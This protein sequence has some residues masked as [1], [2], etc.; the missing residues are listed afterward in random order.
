MELVELSTRSLAEAMFEKLGLPKPVYYVHQLEQGRYRSEVEFHC[1]KERFHASAHWTKLSSCICEYG[2]ASLN[3]AADK[4]I[5]YMETRE[6]K[7]VVNYYQL[8]EQKNSHLLFHIDQTSIFPILG[9]SSKICIV[10]GL[11][12]LPYFQVNYTESKLKDYI[13]PDYDMLKVRFAKS[14]RH[15]HCRII[16][17]TDKT[18]TVTTNWSEF[19]RLAKIHEGDICAFL[20]QGHHRATPGSHHALPL[21]EPLIATEVV[22]RYHLAF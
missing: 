21:D 4:A 12:L 7:V 5:G 8:Q 3:H 20:F 9:Y 22:S 1:T 6:R 2:E 15:T 11:L 10:F 17:G 19:R 16:V 18:A 14:D 13:D